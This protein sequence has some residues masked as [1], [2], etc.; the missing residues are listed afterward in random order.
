[1]YSSPVASDGKVY[2]ASEEGKVNVLKASGEWEVLAVN[3][4]KEPIYS[5]PA[6][7]DGRIYVRTRMALYAFGQ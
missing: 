6:I 3:D 4:L 2:I 1:Y 7:A 5:T